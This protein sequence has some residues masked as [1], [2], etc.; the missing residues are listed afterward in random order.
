MPHVDSCSSLIN[1]L[2]I[3]IRLGMEKLVLRTDGFISPE[4]VSLKKIAGF[5]YPEV[6]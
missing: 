1:E 4:V 2:R 6:S 5:I 3:Y